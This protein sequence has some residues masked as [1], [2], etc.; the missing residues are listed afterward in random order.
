MDAL[1][2]KLLFE[3]LQKVLDTTATANFPLDTIGEFV[4]S[5]VMGFGTT[6]DE[7]II[8][9]QGFR[10]LL[11]D[12]REQ[13]KGLDIQFKTSLIH[14]RIFAQE[15][16]ALF[17]HDFTV[18]I[19]M[20]NEENVL[21]LRFST[22]FEYFNDHWR[23]VHF[24]GSQAVNSEGDTWHRNE[25]I[26]KNEAL[27]K[28]VDEKTADLKNKNAALEQAIQTIKETQDQLLQQEKLASLGQLTA[29]IAHEIKNPLNFVNNFSELSQD[30]IE[31]IEEELEKKP[32]ILLKKKI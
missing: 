3:T 7:K 13:S 23:L 2:E 26:K 31:E 5:D 9:I 4:V 18:T 11:E 28:L 20:G 17:T 8:G 14:R 6:V 25:L 16:A 30:F 22:V 15:N 12:Q 29:G 24:H 1:K 21:P 10:K 32:P 27:Q 19:Q